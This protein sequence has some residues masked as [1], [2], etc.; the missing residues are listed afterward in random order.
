MNQ[1]L[2]NNEGFDEANLFKDEEVDQEGMARRLNLKTQVEIQA[3]LESRRG[4]CKYKKSI[5]QYQID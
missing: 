1:K 2:R 5:I 3:E 4:T